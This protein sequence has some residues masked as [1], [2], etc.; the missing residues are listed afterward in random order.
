MYE[1]IC[2]PYYTD[3][4]RKRDGEDS[5]RQASGGDTFL[6]CSGEIV[7]S[8]GKRKKETDARR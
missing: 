6:D 3:I 8:I 4:L 7:R 5:Q 1:E 2:I